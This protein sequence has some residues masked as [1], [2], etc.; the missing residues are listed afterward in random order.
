MVQLAP[1]VGDSRTAGE[2]GGSRVVLV[3]DVVAYCSSGGAW[4]PAL[5]TRTW[6]MR[7]AAPAISLVFISRDAELTDEHG[8]EV[9]RRTLV[10]HW[11]GDSRTAGDGDSRTGGEQHGPCW[12][13]LAPQAGDSSDRPVS[14]STRTEGERGCGTIHA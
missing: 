1:D 8:R 2:I 14:D 6:A 11:P 4:S 13:F 7:D 9:E 10:T 5:V 3:G 12:Q